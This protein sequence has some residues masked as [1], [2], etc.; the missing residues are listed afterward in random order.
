MKKHANTIALTVLVAGLILVS[1]AQ[2]QTS[3]TALTA[4]IPFE[5][6]VKDKIWPAGEYKILVVNPTS[7][8]RSLLLSRKDG[9]ATV[10]LQ[11][12]NEVGHLNDNARLVFRR[13]EDQYFLAQAWMPADDTGLMIAKSRSEKEVAK[14]FRD[15]NVRTSTV[16]LTQSKH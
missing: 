7:P 9:S 3:N 5:F 11:T 1:P 16:A 15:V 2:A 14:R 6:T 8:N 4:T 12:S 13:Y 10:I